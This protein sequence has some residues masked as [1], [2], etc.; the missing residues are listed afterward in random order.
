[1]PN[2][3]TL[4]RAEQA[5]REGKAPTTQDSKTFVQ[6]GIEH[7]RRGPH[8]GVRSMHESFRLT[9][10]TRDVLNEGTTSLKGIR[11]YSAD[12]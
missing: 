6:E 2:A 1:M 3:D 9:A 8:R 10:R 4:R 12:T 7:V 11:Y 5:R